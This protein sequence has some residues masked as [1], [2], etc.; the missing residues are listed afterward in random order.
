MGRPNAYSPPPPPP[1]QPPDHLYISLSL[2]EDAIPS[3]RPIP[4][5]E[6]GAVGVSLYI[7]CPPQY[8]ML[9]RWSNSL[10][11]A[12]KYSIFKVLIA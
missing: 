4:C 10:S 5:A 1:P 7:R 2:E 8:R 3:S 9:T 6:E 11:A 12:S